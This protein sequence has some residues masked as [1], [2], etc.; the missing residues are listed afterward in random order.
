MAEPTE[1]EREKA[2][3]IVA[4]DHDRR[5]L[6]TSWNTRLASA[7]SAALAQARAEER[8]R[9]QRALLDATASLAAATSAYEQYAGNVRRRSVRDPFFTTRLKDFQNATERA[10]AA[11]R[12]LSASPETEEQ[13]PIVRQIEDAARKFAALPEWKQ[14]ALMAQFGHFMPARPKTEEPRD[15]RQHAAAAES[16][17]P[18]HTDL[19]V[20]PESLDAWL[21]DNPPPAGENN[22]H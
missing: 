11:I 8:E 7:I 9:L 18:G 15:E 2:R 22:D 14:R 3:A 1:A 13:S 5:G 16:E 4:A 20:S 6:D 10:L 12:A 21:A 17:A 19:M